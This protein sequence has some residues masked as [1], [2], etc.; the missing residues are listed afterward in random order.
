[1]TS[2]VD[3]SY[4]WLGDELDL[5][6][7]LAR[8]GFTGE[9]APTLDTLRALTFAHTTT[10][11][12]ENLEAVLGRGVP[13]DLKSLQD[14]MIHRRRGGYCYENVLLFAAALER[15]GFD[16]T[17]QHARVSMG[18]VPL[19][20]ATHAVLRV[21]I[22]NQAWLTDVGFGSGPLEPVELT[23]DR[24]EFSLGAWR[25]RVARGEDALGGE[26]W[27]LHHFGRDGWLDRHTTSMTPQYR[28]DY[29]VG[30]HYVATWPRSPFVTR[31]FIQ[32]FLPE[33]HHVL[34]GTT[35]TTAYPD[36]TSEARELELAELPK[37][38]AEVFDI[39]LDAEAAEKLARGDWP[40]RRE[41]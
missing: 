19:R 24:G 25:Y 23:P 34:D 41:G 4:Q 38:L 7:Y 20:P 1:M 29:E 12:F 36:G 3:P 27:T 16:F 9:R 5:D 39:D 26:Q 35:W 21:V 17:G 18:A 31:P 11:P 14:K 8:I 28:V 22:D 6:A 2:P 40:A 37:V 30:N 32:R 10:F 33:V 15:L 13:L